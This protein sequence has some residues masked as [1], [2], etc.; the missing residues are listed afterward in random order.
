M[1]F[2]TRLK[3]SPSPYSSLLLKTYVFDLIQVFDL[4]D[5]RWI[6]N[7]PKSGLKFYRLVVDS[8]INCLQLLPLA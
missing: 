2:K 7:G 1:K 5:G 6:N 8:R 4:K 3:S